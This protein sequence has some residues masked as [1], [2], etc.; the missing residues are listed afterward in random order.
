MRTEIELIV[1]DRPVRVALEPRKSLLHLLR[2]ELGLMG[3]KE[4]CGEGDCGACVVLLNGK[5]VNSCL[6]LAVECEGI[7]VT[8][9]EGL[10][11]SG[12]LHPLQEAFVE[13]GAVQCGFCTPGMILAAKALLDQVPDPSPD[14]V[15][16]A[17]VGHLCRCTGYAKILEAVRLAARKSGSEE[18]LIDG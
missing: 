14:D 11:V 6:V 13:A 9:I 16:R 17:L 1:N 18:V 2:S 8:T 12:E 15:K 5:P 3:T 7:E 10:A 4:G